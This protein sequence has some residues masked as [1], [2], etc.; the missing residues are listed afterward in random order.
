[1]ERGYVTYLCNFGTPSRELLE[2]EMSNLASRFIA[3]GINEK[4]AELGQRGG[5][6][7]M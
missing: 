7:V 3:R 6:V 5:K 1:M 4:N 2:I